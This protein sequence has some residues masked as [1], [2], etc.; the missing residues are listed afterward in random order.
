M[1]IARHGPAHQS[2]DQNMD[3]RFLIKVTPAPNVRD[4]LQ[5]IIMRDG[6]VVACANIAAN[7]RFIFQGREVDG[8]GLIAFLKTEVVCSERV[9][10]ARCREFHDRWKRAVLSSGPGRVIFIKQ[11]A[12]V[13]CLYDALVV[14]H[15]AALHTNRLWPCKTKPR[16]VFIKRVNEFRL[17]P[18]V[19]DI[20]NAKQARPE[21]KRL[22]RRIGVTEVKVTRG[23]G[24]EAG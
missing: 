14:S 3:W 15:M 22:L 8:N 20:F 7:Q 4:V 2:L 16:Q 12:R 24:G 9:Y 17:G 10:R 23:R 11:A 1:M 18:R 6:D 19:V 5:P 13:Q 21:R